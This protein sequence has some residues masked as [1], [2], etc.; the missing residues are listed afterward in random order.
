[1]SLRALHSVVLA[2]LLLVAQAAAFGHALSHDQDRIDGDLRHDC[3]WCPVFSNLAGPAAEA[4]AASGPVFRT[5]QAP[6]HPSGQDWIEL[7][8][9]YRSQAPPQRS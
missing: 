1:V 7:R 6:V 3:A 9:A 5:E 2:V 4:P 8:L